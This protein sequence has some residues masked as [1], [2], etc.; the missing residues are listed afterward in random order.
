MGDG[1]SSTFLTAQ[2]DIIFFS[3]SFRSS[4]SSQHIISSA[5]PHAVNHLSQPQLQARTSI[6]NSCQ[7]TIQFLLFAR[8]RYQDK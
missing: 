4:S 6:W 8:P 5:Q 3:T 7:T 1:G 2:L